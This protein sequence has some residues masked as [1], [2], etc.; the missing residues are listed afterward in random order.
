LVDEEGIDW[1][2]L[3]SLLW[4]PDALSVL[5]L[6]R[7]AA[8]FKPAA[9]LWAT[10]ES[11]SVSLLAKLLA[12]PVRSFEGTLLERWA[13]RTMRYAGLARRLSAVQVK[14]IFLDKY[15]AGF[16]LRSRFAASQ[17]RC[18]DPVILL[19]SAYGNVSSMAAAYAKLLPRQAFLLVATRQSARRFA[20]P[21]NVE[22]RDLAAYGRSDARTDEFGSLAERWERLKGALQ[23]VPE[24]RVLSEAGVFDPFRA[25]LRDG[26]RAR[27]AWREVLER[28]PVSGVLCGDDS[29]RYTRL[30]VLLAAR[31]RL[32]TVDFHHGA[33]DGRYALKDLPCDVY[34]AKNEME[35]EYLLRVCALPEERV[36]IGA[37]AHEFIPRAEERS[38]GGE[39]SAILFS[40]P[41][42]IAG[43]RAEEVYRE[44]LPQLCRVVREYNRRLIVKLHP[45]ENRAQRCAVLQKI[46]DRE[47]GKLV[48]VVDGP[49]TARLLSQTW[50]G[51]TVESTSVMDCVQNGVTCFLCGW[52]ALSPYEYVEQYTRFGVG[53]VLERAE[54][55]SGIPG[56]LGE[57]SD[58]HLPRSSRAVV[59][60]PAM[61][62]RWLTSADV[63]RSAS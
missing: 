56:R 37:P 48:S 38:P 57:L 63:A 32:P 34:L 8:Q 53:E 58:R 59:A 33:F 47:D 11:G 10:R 1:W 17:E 26:L 21:G 36:V 16:R 45:F 23:D 18:S 4:A 24:L 40:E 2:E 41:Y 44:L 25:W 55:I 3:I 5:M 42:E 22:V 49:L 30:P 52:L 50:F 28:E 62:R 14:E 9:D 12:S 60:D 31:R 39:T 27:D 15:D 7:V 20:P 6:Q 51:I 29:N 54:A 61:L 43:M 19:P 35:R 13:A 46:L